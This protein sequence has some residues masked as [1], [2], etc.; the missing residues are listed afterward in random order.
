MF[1]A[2]LTQAALLKKLVDAIKDLVNDANF[3]V[4]GNGFSLQAMDTSHVSLVAL[5]LRGDGFDHYRCDRPLSLGINMG[6]L[7]K[8]LKCATNDDVC[9][10]KATD[11]ADKLTLMFESKEGDRVSEFDVK[12]MDIDS[13][14]LGIPEQAYNSVITMPSAEFQRIVRDLSTI[15][16]TVVISCTK[17]SI[18]FSVSGDV[19]SANVTVRQSASADNEE[20]NTTIQLDDPVTLS[21]ALR[22]LNLFT[23]A[24][25]LASQVTLS[26]SSDVP[27]VVEYKVETL[28][29]IRYY[30]APKIDDSA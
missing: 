11:E 25:P 1:E 23:R 24:T 3:D 4:S 12:L 13:E 28:G 7:T 2:R 18:K 5:L 15:G 14:H 10:L 21:F 29:H 20:N 9:T 6:S 22:Y 17:E 26:L 8:V 27:L 30:L 19:G 16:D